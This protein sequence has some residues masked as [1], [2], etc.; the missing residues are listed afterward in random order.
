MSHAFTNPESCLHTLDNKCRLSAPVITQN[1]CPL[2][3]AQS[4]LSSA[5]VIYYD[6]AEQHEPNM[7]H[8]RQFCRLLMEPAHALLAGS[9]VLL[10]CRWNAT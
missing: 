9:C 5:I 2:F 3:R 6:T 4:M 10:E 1:V 7:T 8:L